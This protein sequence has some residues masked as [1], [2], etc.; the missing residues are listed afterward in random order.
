MLGVG[1]GLGVGVVV[2]TDREVIHTL[3]RA[4][5]ITVLLRMVGMRNAISYK[6]RSGSFLELLWKENLV[7]RVLENR[8]QLVILNFLY[9][10]S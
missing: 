7:K 3:V 5:V 9:Y 8:W 1:V 4:E 6:L 2:V 10:W